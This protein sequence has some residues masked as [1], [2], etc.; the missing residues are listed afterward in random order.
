[1]LNELRRR[2]RRPR[3]VPDPDDARLGETPDDAPLP[4]E[5]AWRRDCHAAVAAAVAALPP[6]QRQALS[7]A[8]FE[9]LTQPQ[10]AARLGLPLGTAKTRIRAGKQRLRMRLLPLVADPPGTPETAD[11]ER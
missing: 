3:L 2:E 6:A 10:V 5:E 8:Y 7:L 11:S 9:E 4:D 1:M